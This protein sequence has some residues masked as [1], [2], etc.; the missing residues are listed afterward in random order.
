[1]YEEMDI[2]EYAPSAMAPLEE[3]GNILGSIAALEFAGNI[4]ENYAANKG[5][6]K[7]RAFRRAVF[8]TAR[9]RSWSAGSSFRVPFTNMRLKPR[10]RLPRWW[11]STLQNR[12]RVYGARDAAWSHLGKRAGV[13][14]RALLGGD[15]AGARSALLRTNRYAALVGVSR[16]AGIVGTL[17][18]TVPLIQGLTRGAVDLGMSLGRD[19]SRPEWGGSVVN[20]Q[21]AMTQRQA[22]LAAIHN[23]QLQTRSMFAR[24][25]A[26]F[27]Q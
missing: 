13:V 2:P 26:A 14:G 19:Y 20:T 21:E 25:A 16:A 8:N 17:A 10:N 27:H 9:Y 22:G 23:S 6:G 11:T 7:N 12:G 3:G 18:W 1:M 24:E 5:I 15:F 4:V